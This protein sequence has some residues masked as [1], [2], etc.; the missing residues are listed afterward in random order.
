MQRLHRL[1]LPLRGHMSARCITPEARTE[2]MP[3]EECGKRQ[4]SASAEAVEVRR[5]C[6]DKHVMHVT[7]TFLGNIK[8]QGVL[9]A[10]IHKMRHFETVQQIGGAIFN[11]TQIPPPEWTVAA[12]P[13]HSYGLL[14]AVQSSVKCVERRLPADKRSCKSGGPTTGGWDKCGP[15]GVRVGYA[16]IGEPT[17]GSSLLVAQGFLREMG[18][19][20]APALAV[21]P[22]DYEGAAGFGV[23]GSPPDRE[24]C[25]K[26]GSWLL[27]WA[28]AW[29]K[30]VEE[31]RDYE[32]AVARSR[33]SGAADEPSPCGPVRRVADRVLRSALEL[34]VERVAAKGL[35]EIGAKDIEKRRWSRKFGVVHMHAGKLNS[36][37]LLAE[38]ILATQLLRPNGVL[39]IEDWS[40]EAMMAAVPGLYAEQKGGPVALSL[41]TSLDHIFVPIYQTWKMLMYAVPDE[42]LPL[43]EGG[44]A[45][46]SDDEE[47][48][49]V[50]DVP[51][52]GAAADAEEEAA[53]QGQAEDDGS[54]DDVDM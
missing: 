28:P 46:L 45:L 31:M 25:K 22:D 13:A 49:E 40:V 16:E 29:P 37:D 11:V 47:A 32:E 9:K 54:A 5:D 33:A 52:L 48:A 1:R 43:I 17:H 41:R 44:H 34:P 38:V 19:N 21:A 42:D 20:V 2:P 24:K 35:E 12:S 23:D 6:E 15:S 26:L 50:P 30:E 7:D 36:T 51:D 39:I 18:A 14:M 53:L 27:H 3:S 8:T 4:K 10:D